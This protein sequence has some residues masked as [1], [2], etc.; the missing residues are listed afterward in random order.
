[1]DY[2]NGGSSGDDT[3]GRVHVKGCVGCCGGETR[4]DSHV[5]RHVKCSARRDKADVESGSAGRQQWVLQMSG[6]GP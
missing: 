4:E 1:M 2:A 5:E 3:R 6:A